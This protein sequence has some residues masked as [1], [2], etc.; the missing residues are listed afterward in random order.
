M[1][2]LWLALLFFEL[3]VFFNVPFRFFPLTSSPLLGAAGFD[4]V[5]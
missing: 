3:D 5:L 4:D 1:L 2:G